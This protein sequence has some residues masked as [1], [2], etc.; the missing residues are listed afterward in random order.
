MAFGDRI[1]ALAS[2]A[3]HA[4]N[5]SRE[6]TVARRIGTRALDHA[7]F[8]LIELLVV[9]LIV[10]VLAAVAIPLFLGQKGKATDAVAQANAANL[11]VSLT[12]CYAQTSDYSQCQ[13]AAQLPD[14]TIP[15]GSGPG[16]AQVLWQPFGLNAVASVAYA[17]NGDLFGILETLPDHTVTRICQVQEGTY[18]TRGCQSGGA[19]AAYGYGSW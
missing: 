15:W 8:T 18:P 6:L 13:T 10:G 14:D 5:S 9:I 7:G 11:K 2:R 17:S 16:Q 1:S 12:S 3:R 4:E 19:Y